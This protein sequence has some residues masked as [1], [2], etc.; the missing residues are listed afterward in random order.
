MDKNKHRLNLAKKEFGAKNI[1]NQEFEDIKKNN[2]DPKENNYDY[3][4]DLIVINSSLD[5][6]L[7]AIKPQGRYIIDGIPTTD[8]ISINPH[9]ARIKE[10]DL[11]NVRRSNI[12]FDFIQNFIIKNSIPINSL[13]THYFNLQDIQNGFN[14]A[15]EYKDN[16]I[17][18]VIV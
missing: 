6:G 10:I 17:R 11:I 12:K 15:A 4:F 3:I 14:I 5:Y 16:I 2:S 8:Y 1:I 7:K 9:K 13:V 18:G